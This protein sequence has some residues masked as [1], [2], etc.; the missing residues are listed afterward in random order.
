MLALISRQW[1]F[2]SS[3]TAFSANN[4]EETLPASEYVRSTPLCLCLVP[5][6][7]F[8]VTGQAPRSLSLLAPWSRVYLLFTIPDNYMRPYLP[9]VETEGFS[10][11]SPTIANDRYEEI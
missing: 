3:L 8:C 9:R 10:K 7:P 11:R 2:S 6:E 5:R 4:P 1:L